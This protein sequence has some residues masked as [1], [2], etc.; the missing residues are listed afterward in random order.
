[1]IQYKIPK[2]YMNNDE[3]NIKDTCSFECE[4]QIKMLFVEYGEKM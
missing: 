1:M 2:N 4:F 3:Q